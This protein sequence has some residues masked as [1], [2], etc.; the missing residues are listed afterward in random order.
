MCASYGHGFR[1][2]DLGQLY[3]RFANPTNFYQVIGNPNLRPETSQ[4]MQIGA[5][6]RAQR[7]RANIT[8][9]NNRVRNL[10]DSTNIGTPRTP[11]DAAALLARYSIPPDYN[12]ILNRP[13]FLYQNLSRALTRG[14]EVDAEVS[15]M[16]NWHVRGVYT[17]LD[18]RDVLTD[19][20]LAQRHRN[21]GFAG[22]E[23]TVPRWG[24]SANMRASYYS[25]WLLNSAAGTRA[26]GYSIYDLY[27]SKQIKTVTA[28][29]SIDNLFDSLD[30]KLSQTP[31]TFD[32]PDYGRTCRVGMRWNFPRE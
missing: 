14:V 4:S 10:I 1:A 9:F 23:Y 18:A 11:A 8:L 25:Y 3:Y 30:R 26:Y 15:L 13:I 22:T 5:G 16:R 17:Y 7:W 31:P 20:R 27:C 6:W 19:L 21:Q 24:L 28:Y 32:R 12:P 2:P 29:A